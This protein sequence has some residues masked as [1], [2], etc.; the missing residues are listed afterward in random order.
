MSQA[1]PRS[2]GAFQNSLF[3]LIAVGAAILGLIAGWL[4]FAPSTPDSDSVDAGFARDMSEHHAQAVE[5]SLIALQKSEATD[6]D[7]LAY[8]IATTQST[9]I[10]TMQG[11]LRQWSLPSARSEPRMSWMSE[12]GAGAMTMDPPAEPGTEDFSAMPGMATPAQLEQLEG[13]AATDAEI[14]FLQ[15]MI[16]HH[17]AGVDMARAAAE[18][19]ETL[20]TTRLA[21]AMV[22]GQRSEIDLMTDLLAERD[23]VPR[24]RP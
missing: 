2:T 8:D 3:G 9:Q 7:L 19:A 24:E 6:I 1:S 12:A 20:E 18:S 13:A 4:I 21:E 23:A 11:W 10:G 17:I 22:T 16:T 5:M 14:L 15:L